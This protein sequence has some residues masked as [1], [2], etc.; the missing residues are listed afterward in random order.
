MTL[1]LVS[2]DRGHSRKSPPEFHIY[3]LCRG[4]FAL[5]HPVSIL[6]LPGLPLSRGK[7]VNVGEIT[8]LAKFILLIKFTH[9]AAALFRRR[10]DGQFGRG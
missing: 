5:Q 2:R 1:A 10:D 7:K 9:S 6:P 4:V 3:A 8:V